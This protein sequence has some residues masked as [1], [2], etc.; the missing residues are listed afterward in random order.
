MPKQNPLEFHIHIDARWIAPSLEDLLLRAHGFEAMDFDLASSQAPCY[1][2]DR[3]LTRKVF[4]ALDF[5]RSFDTVIRLAASTRAIQG[6]IEGEFVARNEVIQGKP[7]DPTAHLDLHFDLRD[8]DPGQFRESEV[9]ITFRRS[10]PDPRLEQTLLASGFF[11]ALLPKPDGIAK[12]F[13]AHGSRKDIG[14]LM[15]VVVKFLGAVGGFEIV[16]VK[17]ERIARWWISDSF[18][19]VPPVIHRLQFEP[20]T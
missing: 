5:K 18:L 10:L 13:T 16:K 19:P 20:V 8:L 7:F 2:P 15:P 14:A 9:H 11:A 6:Y 12:V 3:H 4:D 17:E 1:A